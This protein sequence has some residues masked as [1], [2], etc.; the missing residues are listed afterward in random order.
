MGDI[1]QVAACREPGHRS[2]CQ[3]SGLACRYS[4]HSNC[5][6]R[7]DAAVADGAGP[8]SLASAARPGE[9]LACHRKEPLP[10]G[11]RPTLS[12]RTI[13]RSPKPVRRWTEPG[14][15]PLEFDLP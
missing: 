5:W 8:R 13:A 14:G 6:L 15:T 4:S 7:F 3:P 10:A 2:P 11:P 1:R 12:K 9:P